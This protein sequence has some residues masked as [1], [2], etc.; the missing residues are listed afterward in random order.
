MPQW[1]DGHFCKDGLLK[2]CQGADKQQHKRARA[3]S[4]K[5]DERCPEKKHTGHV[6]HKVLGI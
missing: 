3:K 4:G 1:K 6:S 2:D 5:T